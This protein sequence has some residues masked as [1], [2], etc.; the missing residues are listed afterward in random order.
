M[1]IDSVYVEGF[2]PATPVCSFVYREQRKAK[3]VPYFLFSKSV[4]L[5]TDEEYKK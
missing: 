1:V 2:M 5:I 4:T 3:I